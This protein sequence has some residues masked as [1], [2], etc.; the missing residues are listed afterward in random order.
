MPPSGLLYLCLFTLL[1]ACAPIVDNAP[2]SANPHTMRLGDLLGPFD[3]LVVD[4]DTERPI[5]GAIVEGTWAFERGEGL[6][7]PYLSQSVSTETTADGRYRLPRLEKL[8]AGKT[9]HLVRFTLIAFHRGFV[10]YRSDFKFPHGE[11]RHDFSQRQNKVLLAK[12]DDRFSHQRHRRFLGGGEAIRRA[13]EF[14]R[15]PAALELE[16]KAVR[17]AAAGAAPFVEPAGP[18]RQL[19][20]ASVL[21]SEDELRGATGFGGE[22]RVERLPDRVRTE[23]YDSRHFKAEG[24]GEDFDMAFRVWKLPGTAATEQFEKL[25]REL[26]AAQASDE[27]GDRSV[28]ARGGEVLGLAF[29]VKEKGWVVQVS[30]GVSQCTDPAMVL[31]LAKLIES[32]FPDLSP[33]GS[34]GQPSDTSSAGG[35]P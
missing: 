31:R 15:Q 27:I 29:L 21:L 1:A 20:D 34:P 14:M 4:A 22:F 7:G 33:P 35:A 17:L 30:C 9:T 19:L 18:A 6:T 32:H 13:A 24:K 28:R 10:A 16:G 11:V 2:F 25:A 23:S 12:W 3:G 26:P 5:A 8:P